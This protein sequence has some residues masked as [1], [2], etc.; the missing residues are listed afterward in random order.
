[1]KK[2]LFLSILCITS[3]AL[4]TTV[5]SDTEVKLEGL[6]HFQSGFKSQNKLQSTEKNLSKHNKAVAFYTEAALAATVS[7]TFKDVTYGGKVVLMPTT[8]AKRSPS[9]NGSH[10]FV[11]SGYGKVEAGSPYDAGSKMRITAY[12][13][14]AATGDDFGT[15]ANL[16]GANVTYKE[17]AP[18]F[19]FYSFFFDSTHKIELNQLNDKTEPS[20]KISYFTPKMQ[21]FQVG[22][23][24]IPDSS[25]VAVT[26]HDRLGGGRAV[27]KL[28]SEAN[29]MA[30]SLDRNVRNAFSAGISYE[31]HIAD[32]VD[33][34]LAATGE[35]GN[36]AGKSAI[37]TDYSDNTKDGTLYKNCKLSDLRTYN[38]G[39]ILTHGNFSYAVSYG[40]LGKSLTSKEYHKGGRSTNYYNGAIAYGQGPIKT[41]LSYFKSQQF[42]N[43]LDAV[44]LGTEYKLGAGLL[45]YAEIAYFQAKGKPSFYSPE[46]PN[47]KTKGTVAII[48]A[49]LK[50]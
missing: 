1:M 12:D 47:K 20:R 32:G 40:S 25:N 36:S 38:L 46:A 11:E 28:P 9:Y 44:T 29:K 10:L 14:A 48:G 16:A 50:L 7:Q 6:F 8:L 26:G 5:S 4:A 39:A 17:L 31:H 24:Y 34:K 45:P 49:K 19:A 15:Y 23:S 37:Y 3:S 2:I 27:V 30:A 22:V 35:Y 41:S 43:T 42:K 33:L 21:G 13:I 18:E